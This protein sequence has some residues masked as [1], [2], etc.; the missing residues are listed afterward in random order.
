MNI[1]MP[2][3]TVYAVSVALLAGGCA[4]FDPANPL[5]SAPLERAVAKMGN[6]SC[7][8]ARAATQ[9]QVKKA[10]GGPQSATTF[11]GN[12][13]CK[14]GGADNVEVIYVKDTGATSDGILSSWDN[15]FRQTRG[16]PANVKQEFAGA[17]D[18]SAFILY[19]ENPEVD[20]AARLEPNGRGLRGTVVVRN[21]NSCHSY[22][23]ACVRM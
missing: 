13:R 21:T 16:F 3:L 15:D 12:W 6:P 5:S 17:H 14:A 7:E 1:A 22:E 9:A 8:E 11:G 10:H 4:G 23:Y 2:T 19:S 20:F 18:G